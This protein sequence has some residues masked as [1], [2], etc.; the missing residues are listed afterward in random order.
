MERKKPITCPLSTTSQIFILV[1]HWEIAVWAVKMSRKSNSRV[2][3]LTTPSRSVRI[4]IQKLKF[5]AALKNGKLRI[6]HL[7]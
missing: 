3:L 6:L 7:N 4:Q 5:A 2:C 1:Q